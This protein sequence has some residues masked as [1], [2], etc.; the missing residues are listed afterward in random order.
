MK[1]YTNILAAEVSGH[2]LA[3][4]AIILLVFPSS[5]RVLCIAPGGHAAIEDL[6]AA[7]CASCGTSCR[8]D[9]QMHNGLAAAQDCRDC[10]DYL[11]TPNARGA[12][13]DSP[14]DIAPSTRA[15]ATSGNQTPPLASLSSALYRPD[16]YDGRSA[17][18]PATSPVPLRC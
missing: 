12:V 16:K 11:I 18:A 8:S 7:C 2:T 6:G 1:L 4:L 5:A 3:V 13:L 9:G 10:A 17:L 15:H 14:D